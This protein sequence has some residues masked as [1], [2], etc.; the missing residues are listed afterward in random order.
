[1]EA[2]AAGTANR[3]PEAPPAGTANRPAEASDEDRAAS[4]NSR[5]ALLICATPS[6]VVG[7]VLGAVVAAVAAPL[8]GLVVFVVVTLMLT[9]WFRA[10]APHVVLKVLGARPSDEGQHPRVHNLVEGL[11]ATMGLPPPAIYVVTSPTPN[12]LAVGREPRW[13]VLVVTS[14]LEEVLSLVE[15]EGVLAHELVHVKRRDTATAGA[16]VAVVAPLAAITG[17]GAGLVRSLVGAG[18]EFVADQRAA[19][20]VRY[21]PGLASAL[22]T[23]TLTPPSASSWP[24]GPG[25]SAAITRWLW[26]D[27]MVGARSENAEGNLDDTAVRAAALSER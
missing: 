3:L 26:I 18:R 24:P 10:R 19:S 5:R 14:G 21:P 16:A 12:A 2:S 15:L 9:T 25:R 8:I 7:L 23:M 13:A 27:P 4:A 20:V 11:C 17:S 1:M 22:E 6:V